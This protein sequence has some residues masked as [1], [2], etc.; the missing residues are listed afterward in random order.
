MSYS[1]L[2]T[3]VSK[4]QA[5]TNQIS[6]NSW[7][8]I[9][10][11][12]I[13]KYLLFDYF[14]SGVAISE[15]GSRSNVFCWAYFCFLHD[16]ILKEDMNN[17]KC[18]QTPLSFQTQYTDFENSIHYRKNILGKQLSQAICSKY[19]FRLL[20]AP[21]FQIFSKKLNIMVKVVKL[22]TGLLWKSGS[23]EFYRKTPIQEPLF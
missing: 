18:T 23:D 2:V 10:R 17:I 7:C 19:V 22:F 6:R 1:M 15:V 16:I 5:L 9:T 8:Q 4:N 14:W 20:C 13:W 21:K 12:T 3:W 11:R